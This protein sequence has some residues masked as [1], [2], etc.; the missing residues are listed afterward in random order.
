M[1]LFTGPFRNAELYRDGLVIGILGGFTTFSAF[2]WE[3][4]Q[5]LDSRQY[6][7]ASLYVGLSVGAGLLATLIGLRFSQWIYGT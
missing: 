6:G 5:L 3:T 1:A 7:S 2:G 4:I